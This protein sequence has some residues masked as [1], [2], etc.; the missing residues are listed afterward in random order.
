MDEAFISGLQTGWSDAH[1][2]AAAGQSDSHK[3]CRAAVHRKA[4]R[5]LHVFRRLI[6]L[7]EQPEA[8]EQEREKGG[9][10]KTEREFVLFYSE[11]HSDFSVDENMQ[12]L[13]DFLFL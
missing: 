3:L 10:G 4:G 2:A 11:V 6:R 7:T 1:A 8:V 13:L 5:V 9:M 12:Q